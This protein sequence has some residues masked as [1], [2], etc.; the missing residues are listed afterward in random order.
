MPE[1]KKKGWFQ[2]FRQEKEAFLSALACVKK[3]LDQFPKHYEKI[4]YFS[5]RLFHD[6]HRL[7]QSTLAGRLFFDYLEAISQMILEKDTYIGEA[8]WE[9]IVYEQFYL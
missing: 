8:E 5:Y 9:N 7:D 4:P 2:T 1:E 6:P 3:A